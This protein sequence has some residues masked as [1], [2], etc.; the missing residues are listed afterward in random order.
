M[1]RSGSTQ[2]SMNDSDNR[3]KG[4]RYSALVFQFVCGH[5]RGPKA[6]Y[7]QNIG[8]WGAPT[9]GIIGDPAIVYHQH[10]MITKYPTWPSDFAKLTL[11]QGSD[12]AA[13]RMEKVL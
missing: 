10:D 9:V 13:D 2:L 12:H 6:R 5:P 8:E 7:I 4:R 3:G 11:T 1:Y